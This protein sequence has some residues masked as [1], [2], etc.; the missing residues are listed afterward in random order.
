MATTIL[1]HINESKSGYITEHLRK[2]IFYICNP[3]KT[4]NKLWVGSNCGQ[5]EEEIYKEMV[6]TKQ[7]F[8]K[9]WGRQGY[10]YVL[11]FVPGEGT[12]ELAYKIGKEFLEELLKGEYE[13]VYAVH[14]DQPHL[15]I[16]MVFNSVNRIT[17]YK[18]RYNNGDWEKIIQPISD[19]LCKKYGLSP[20]TYDKKEKRKGVSYAENKSRKENKFTWKRIIKA[21]IDY[22]ISVSNTFD[23]YIEQMKKFGYKIR[24]G[25]SRIHGKYIAYSH[26]GLALK[27]SKKAHRDYN[28]GEDYI[29]KNIEKRIA[30]GDKELINY[31]VKDKNFLPF[32]PYPKSKE[33]YQ[34]VAFDR[35]RQAYLYQHLDMR[36]KSQIRA[37]KDLLRIDKIE[38]ECSYIINNNIKSY[39]EIEERKKDVLKEI[40]RIYERKDLENDFIFSEEEKK[41]RERY[42]IISKLLQEKERS[43]S[44]EEYESLSDELFLLEEKYNDN[45]IILENKVPV[46]KLEKLKEEKKILNRIIKDKENFEEVEELNKL[47]E[48]KKEKE[49]KEKV[50]ESGTKNEEKKKETVKTI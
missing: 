35:V 40:N 20:L 45:P 16:H 48:L 50:P 47:Q 22:S 11:S 42:K 21:D 6:R 3:K 25:N 10:H 28:L 1:K 7:R 5:T 39:K 44:D 23:E 18:Y 13:Y 2:S 27:E 49:E 26:P 37:R 30:L 8:G 24:I 4:M 19:R 9:E 32:I 29:I 36:I 38:S 33:R 12:E 34:I 46:E 15:H 31:I 17:G 41:D 43:L 14:N